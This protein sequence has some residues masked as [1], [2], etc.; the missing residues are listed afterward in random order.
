MGSMDYF[1]KRLEVVLSPNQESFTVEGAVLENVSDRHVVPQELHCD[2]GG[3][4]EFEV[5]EALLNLL[6]IRDNN[7]RDWDKFMHSFLLSYE[8]SLDILYQCY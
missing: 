5:W 2:Q 1:L 7:Q 4:F 3:N 6:G 8:E